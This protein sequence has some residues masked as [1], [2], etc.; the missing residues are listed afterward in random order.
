M[1]G[2]PIGELI[3]PILA[4]AEAMAGFQAML[5]RCPTASDRKHLIMAAW[6]RGALG[7][8]DAELLIQANMLETA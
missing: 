7:D 8:D 2:R 6:E 5:A 1:S 3:A 4:R